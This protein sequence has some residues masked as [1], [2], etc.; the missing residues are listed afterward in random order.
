MLCSQGAFR[1]ACSTLAGSEVLLVSLRRWLHMR[2]DG[3]YRAI[4]PRKAVWLIDGLDRR[5]QNELRSFLA[6]AGLAGVALERMD[7]HRLLVC[8]RQSLGDGRLLVVE[9]AASPKQS[10]GTMV[11]RRLVRAIDHASRGRL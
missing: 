2:T 10:D 3:E 8:V 5:R 11:S 6:R 7:D 9:K 4:E 1:L